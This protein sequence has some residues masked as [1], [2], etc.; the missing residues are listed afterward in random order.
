MTVFA[1]D[2]SYDKRKVHNSLNQ[3]APEAEILIPPRKNAHIWKQGNSKSERHKRDENLR[4]IRKH[5]RKD[6]KQIFGYHA[7]SL[8]DTAVFRC[9]TSSLTNFFRTFDRNAEDTSRH[10]LGGAHTYDPFGNARKLK[11]CLTNP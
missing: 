1:A 2:S 3:Y 4:Y 8:A 6:W 7:R 9:K 5:G 11:T 10:L